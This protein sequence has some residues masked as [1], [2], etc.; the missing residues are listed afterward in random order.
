MTSLT[1]LK[2]ISVTLFAD[3]TALYYSAKCSTDFRQMLNEDLASVA[4]WLNDHRRTLNLAKS[5]F[6]IIGSS[7]RLKS[8]KFVMSS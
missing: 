5:K 7:P 1:C 8:L 3:D 2:H 6:M 4:K